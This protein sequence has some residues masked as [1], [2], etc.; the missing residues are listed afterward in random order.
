MPDRRLPA[1]IVALALAGLGSGVAR[2]ESG[3]RLPLPDRFGTIP[4]STYDEQGR[5][6]GDAHLVIEKLDDRRVRILSESGFDGG[7]RNVA[8]AELAL[9]DSG[10]AL[11]PLNQESR[12]FTPDGVPMGV[13]RIDHE[14]GEAS[15]ASPDG[16]GMKVDRVSLPN[17]DR[18]A[19]VPLNLLFLPLVRG[20]TDAVSFQVFLCRG[21]ARLLKAEGHVDGDGKGNG[22]V[23]EVRYGPDLGRVISLMAPSLIPSYSVWFGPREPH[24]WMAHRIPLFSKGPEVLVI[25]E[26]IEPLWLSNGH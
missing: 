23:V 16:D 22:H 24:A 20:E 15:C 5:R 3:L 8:T 10:R 25:R 2:A 26:G 1:L 17:A 11:R 6:V 21:G 13:L 9:V 7:A 4:A 18:V 12:S 14:L 19:N